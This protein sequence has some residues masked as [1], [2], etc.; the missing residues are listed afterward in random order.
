[1]FLLAFHASLHFLSCHLV[2][3]N[4]LSLVM[5]LFLFSS[6]RTRLMA[7]Q[8]RKGQSVVI[9][10]SGSSLCPMTL[11]ISHLNSSHL[12]LDSDEYICRP[13]SASNS[14]KRLVSVHKPIS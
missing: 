14:C 6:K 3:S 13:I 10:E 5:A 1:M 9:A 7:D 8:L 2:V 4:I 12:S 11:L